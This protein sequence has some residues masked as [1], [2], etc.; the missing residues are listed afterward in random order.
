[1]S[2]R[3][4]FKVTFACAVSLAMSLVQQAAAI[5]RLFDGGAG[6]AG[7]DYYTPA[8]W[9]S[10]AFPTAQFHARGVIGAVDAAGLLSP[11][12]NVNTTPDIVTGGQLRQS[13]SLVLGRDATSTGTLDINNGGTARFALTANAAS[14]FTNGAVYLGLFPSGAGTAQ[15]GIGN[16]NI[17]GNGT[18]IATGMFV[19]GETV[20]TTRSSVNLSGNATVTLGPVTNVFTNVTNGIGAD[21]LR[22]GRNLSIS[23]PS[24]NFTNT[25][26]LEIQATNAYT[27]NITSAT[28]HSAIKTTGNVSLTG[29]L[30]INF[31]GLATNPAVNQ[32]WNL[33][34][35]GGNLFGSFSN[36]P[37]N[38][39]VTVTGLPE[40]IEL[41]AAFKLRRVDGGVNGKLVQLIQQ[42]LVVL[43]AN[44]ETGE[45][46]LTNPH[47]ADIDIDGYR[48]GSELGSLLPTYKGISGAPAGDSGWE[49]P[50]TNST[51]GLAELKSQPFTTFDLQANPS[52]TLGTGAGKG[53]DKYAVA[54]DVANF[55]TDGEDLEFTYSTPDGP[56]VGHIEYIGK[57]F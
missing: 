7:T 1:M 32:T 26:N 12:V 35:Y 5:D 9:T 43:Q 15:G 18:L 39:D 44:R 16:L 31:S 4:L 19:E 50:S 37:F 34:D 36:A 24:V 10:D 28:A 53:F 23:G 46:K 6:G 47:G 8:N 30:N 25:G 2:S 33:I 55:G 54:A 57:K 51:T 21:N 14:A 20:G 27:S 22:F 38:T 11:T 3:M 48:I 42:G 52:V 45:M 29:T 49:K 41:G 13:G 40:P 56:V 17:S